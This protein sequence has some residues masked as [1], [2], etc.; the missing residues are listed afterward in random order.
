MRNFKFFV[1]AALVLAGC[2]SYTVKNLGGSDAMIIIP[3]T[4]VSGTKKVVRDALLEATAACRKVG[5]DRVVVLNVHE[6]SE[7]LTLRVQC[8]STAQ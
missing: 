6:T 2:H 5:G 4:S 1:V 7:E 8:Q 3:I